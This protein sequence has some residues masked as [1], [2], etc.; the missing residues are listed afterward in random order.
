MLQTKRTATTEE[1]CEATKKGSEMNS[2][3]SKKDDQHRHDDASSL[4]E[5]FQVVLIRE[6]FQAQVEEVQPADPAK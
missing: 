2:P 1:R 3:P 6:I 5:V 4:V